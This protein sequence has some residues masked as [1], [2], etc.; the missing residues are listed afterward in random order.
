MNRGV[1]Q[2]CPLSALLFI[3]CVEILAE[4]CRSANT[5][6]GFKFN[7]VNPNKSIY[8]SQY[9]DDTCLFLNN[10]SDIDKAI[11]IVIKFGKFSGLTLNVSKTKVILCT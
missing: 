11:D 2:G 1:R 4:I 8:A 9:A 10:S 7:H 5:F 6:I 3:I